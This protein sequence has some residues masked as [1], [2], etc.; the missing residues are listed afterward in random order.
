MFKCVCV[1]VRVHACF[2]IHVHVAVHA[3]DALERRAF[4]VDTL[5]VVSF[6]LAGQADREEG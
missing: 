3:L 4:A 5:G 6:C 2:C 1:C